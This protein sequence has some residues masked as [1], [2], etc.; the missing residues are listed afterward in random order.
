MDINADTQKLNLYRWF[1]ANG[2]VEP[3]ARR[4]VRLLSL[5]HD[6]GAT[7]EKEERGQVGI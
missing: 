7:K 3:G 2:R 4:R 6:Y 5:L 1:S